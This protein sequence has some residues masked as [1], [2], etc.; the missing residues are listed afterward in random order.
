MIH[1]LYYTQIRL[2]KTESLTCHKFLSAEA[3]YFH[4]VWKCTKLRP[5]WSMV[6]EFITDKFAVPNICSPLRCLLGI[7]EQ[8][9]FDAQLFLQ[10]LY[11]GGRKLI[12]RRWISMEKLTLG[13]WMKVINYDIL[14]YRMRRRVPPPPQEV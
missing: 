7:F 5:L 1:Q 14:L 12:V 2:C 8:E 13:M 11:F 9:E 6:T 3:T 10:I 4:M